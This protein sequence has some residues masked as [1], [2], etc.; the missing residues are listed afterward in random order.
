MTVRRFLRF[1]NEEGILAS[2]LWSRLLMLARTAPW[3]DAKTLWSLC[4]KEVRTSLRNGVLNEEE[5]VAM[6]LVSV[7]DAVDEACPL[8]MP[9]KRRLRYASHRMGTHQK[10]AAAREAVV[11]SGTLGS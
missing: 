10:R 7:R 4:P 6:L 3:H 1:K 2:T 5:G 11:A 9:P 8:S